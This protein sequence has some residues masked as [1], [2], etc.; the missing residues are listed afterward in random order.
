MRP[1]G[2]TL[3]VLGAGTMGRGI[4]RAA[5]TAGMRVV[6]YDVDRAAADRVAQALDGAGTVGAGTV[7]ADVAGAVRDA[8]VVL[9]CVPEILAVKI[10]TLAEAHRHARPAAL[11]GTNT[12][13][14]SIAALAAAAGCPGRLLGLH[15][16]NPAEK[17]RLV[18]VVRAPDTPPAEV[19]R[20]EAFAR[21]L[22]KTP[23]VVLDAPGFV[24]SRLG[25][26]LGNEAML[27]LQS[28]IASASAIDAAMRLGFNHPMGPLE[29]ADLVGLDARL[30]NLRT[31]HEARREDRFA[32]PQV[33]VDL[34]AA[35]QLGLKTGAGF[36]RYDEQRTQLGEAPLPGGAA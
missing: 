30:N 2:S 5:A 11:L 13:T 7:A 12:S 1:E 14:M 6:L 9:E 29:L 16:F 36:Y 31:L 34:V 10:A 22:G 32:P 4:A 27:V 15:F 26:A 20:G 23:I 18:E 33:L 28:G 25:L 21:A 17:M 3:A 19:R 24:T 8:D 35:N